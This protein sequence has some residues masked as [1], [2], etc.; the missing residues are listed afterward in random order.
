MRRIGGPLEGR[1]PGTVGSIG[2][3][4]F[5]GNKI[6][7][8][9]GGGMLV[10][11]DRER[12]NRIRHISQQAKVPGSDYEHDA[13]GFNYRLSHIAAAIGSVQLEALNG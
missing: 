4:S 6:M 8:T 5:N 12:L 1:M 9:G 3:Y 7:T 11:P 13:I 2:I 10:S